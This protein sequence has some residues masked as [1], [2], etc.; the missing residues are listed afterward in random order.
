MDEVEQK[1]KNV[2]LKQEVLKKLSDAKRITATFIK[3]VE[4]N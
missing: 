3:R 1:E 4:N 2:A